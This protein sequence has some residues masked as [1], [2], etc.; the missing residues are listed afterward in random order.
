MRRK[1]NNKLIGLFILCGVALFFA[2]VGMFVSDKMMREGDRLV[3]MY[4]SESIK[5]LDVGSPVV[6]KGVAIGKVAKIDIITD[7]QDFDF[8]IPVYVSFN[9]KKISSRQPRE[10]A[11]QVLKELVENGLRAR[12]VSQNML[13]GQ[14]MIELE[15][16]PNADKAVYRSRPGSKIPEIPT[17]LSQLAELSRGIQELPLRE[18]FKKMNIFLDS[19][20]NDVVPQMTKVINDFGAIPS[21]TREV[22]ATLNNFNKAM[23]N[24]SNAAKSLGNFA[25]YIERHPESLLRG[26]GGY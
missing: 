22:P 5:G 6:F 17:V 25:D 24:I 19:L 9:E 15:F 1:P 8:S 26:K 11:H 7:L 10:N 2:T 4:F 21:R 3:V 23:Q 14:L 13:T 18:T 20:N 16:V 12:L